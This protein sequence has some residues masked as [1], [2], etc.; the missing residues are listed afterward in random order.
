MQENTM[1]ILKS[2]QERWNAIKTDVDRWG[3]VLS[4]K[5]E[6]GIM[7]DNDDTCV[8]FHPELIPDSIEDIDDLPELNE[9]DEWIGNSPGLDALME[10]LGIDAN[11]V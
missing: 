1:G 8:V 4:H 2:I 9:F 3:Y 10:V 6:L 7:L 5:N 11:G